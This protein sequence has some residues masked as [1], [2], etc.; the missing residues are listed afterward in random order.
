M[1]SSDVARALQ[2][3]D[4]NVR[5]IGEERQPRKGTPDDVIAR[6]AQNERRYVFT[7]NFDMIL[8]AVAEGAAFIWFF[9]GEQN[10]LTKFDTAWLFFRKW[11][12]WERMLAN[13]SIECLRVS[14]HRSTPTTF[15]R[16]RRQA[17]EQ[18]RKRAVHVVARSMPPRV[19]PRGTLSFEDE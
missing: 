6:I 5:W 4:K 17:E 9:D 15:E 3:L 18:I 14:R 2:L 7:N 19:Q 10:A 8:A 16:A 12:T 11:E 1:M 13:E